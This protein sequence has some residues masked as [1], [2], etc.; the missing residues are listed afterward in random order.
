MS[1]ISADIAMLQYSHRENA[2]G[3]C[4]ISRHFGI[5][6]FDIRELLATTE[7][8]QFTFRMANLDVAGVKTFFISAVQ[9]LIS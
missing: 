6:D 4:S 8:V 7:I 9:T 1:K 5:C 2:E 3:L